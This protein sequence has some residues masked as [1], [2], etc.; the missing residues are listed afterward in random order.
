MNNTLTITVLANI[1]SNYSESI[2]NI[3]AVQKTYKNGKVYAMRSKESVKH[4]VL[5]QSRFYDDVVTVVN[6]AA[7]KLANE[8]YNACNNRAYEA[9]YL[10]TGKNSYSRKS[11][12][13]FT[14]AVSVNPFN[15]EY[16]FHTNLH[17]AS[18]HAKA[19]G[20]KLHDQ[21]EEEEIL[22]LEEDEQEAANDKKKEKN[23]CGLMPYQYEFD[24]SVKKF[25]FTLFLDE[26]GIDENFK[27]AVVSDKEKADRVN[28]LLDTIQH[29]SMRVKGNLDNA[30]PLFIIGGLTKYRTHIFENLVNVK[31]NSVI[32]SKVLKNR[33][34]E[35][36][37]CGVLECGFFD[38]E[39]EIVSE[40]NAISINEFF[41][42]LRKAVKD[43][44]GV[45]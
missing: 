19:N 29:L 38:N 9:G 8:E 25:S 10:T 31:N 26:I 13:C 17:L 44:Y 1:T 7:Q 16:R 35:G 40:L 37:S 24:Y 20:L 3:S 45:K 28:T 41:D 36:F 18:A 43:Y 42:N 39:E 34:E 22:E 21:R 2:G 6:S 11:S 12:F 5:E 23:P 15:A 14:D 27:D 30:E 33:V 4:E 32:V